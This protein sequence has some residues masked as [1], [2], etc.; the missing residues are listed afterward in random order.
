[1]AIPLLLLPLLAS[2]GA[3]DPRL[4]LTPCRLPDL[5]R[6]VKCGTYEVF[7]NRSARIGH[8]IALRVAVIPAAEKPVKPD[9]VVYFEGGPGGS[10]IESGP[11]LVEEF[12]V[13]LRHRDLVLVDARGTGESNNLRCPATEGVRGV[14]EAL[15][16]FLEP[17]AVR[18][19]RDAL[20]KENDLRQYTTEAIVDDVDEVRSAL[21]Y[22]KVNLLGASYGT[23]AALVYLR[24]HPEAVRTVNLHAAV[25]MDARGP[26]H[27]A[28]YA[29]S[30]FDAQAARCAAGA[31]CRAAYP[32]PRGDLSAVLARLDQGPVE[33]EIAT[34]EEQKKVMRLTRNGVIQTVRYLLYSPAGASQLPWLLRRAAAGDLAPLAQRAYGLATSLTGL[35]MS[36][37]YLSVTCAEDIAFLDAAEAARLAKGTFVGDL[38]VRQQVAGCAQWPA[39]KVGEEF[40]APV[41]STVPVLL[42]TGEYDPAT[43]REGAEQVAQAL[44]NSRTLIVPGGAHVFYGL[45][46]IECL[47]RLAAEMMDKGPVEGLDL[48]ACRK[49]IKPMPFQTEPMVSSGR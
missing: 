7:E 9:A 23:R 22:G 38:R 1:M 31:A 27:L 3:D 42:F 2:L 34:D 6:E 29:Q 13:A 36:G 4:A 39:P 11:G 45:E 15:D 18:R 26:Q 21:G 19:C 44:P 37:L 28:P 24:R 49:S 20:A 35:A 46:G 43:P 14:E 8:K 5:D 48:E 40:L 47:D 10:A 25:P 32:D 12:P 33:V 30:A 16:S 41:R 17:E